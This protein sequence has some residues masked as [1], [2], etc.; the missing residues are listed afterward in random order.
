MK[1][2]GSCH[3]RQ[4]TYEAEIDP[5]RVGACNC[6]DCQ[7]MTGS[8]FRVSVVVPAERFHLAS[9]KPTTYVKTADSGTRRRHGFCGNCGTPVYAA[10][11][12][13]APP[14][15]TLRIGCLAEKRELAPK[16]QI[17]KKSALPWVGTVAGLPGP[18]GQQ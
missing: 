5:A 16:G 11:D 2:H 15:Y 14:F 4:I 3:C 13:D 1:V 18:D 7:M 10:A 12:V 17:W 8:A 6:T 9:G